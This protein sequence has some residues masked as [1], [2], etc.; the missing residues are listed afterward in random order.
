MTVRV[1]KEAINLREKLS[2]L[3]FD[4]VPFQKM[5]AGS[6]LQVVST[7]FNDTHG[8]ATSVITNTTHYASTGLTPLISVSITP[9]SSNSYFYISLTG[10]FS[11][12]NTQRSQILL[13]R[14]YT[15]GT[16]VYAAGDYIWHDHY[17]IFNTTGGNLYTPGSFSYMDKAQDQTVGVARSYYW[18]GGTIGGGTQI[19]R[20]LNATVMEIAQ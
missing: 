2:E 20:G 17:G 11:Q 14:N 15:A 9:K 16:N 8:V 5:P 18:F 19:F 4:R 1:Q 12:S 7:N 10:V 13:T 3:E 6:V